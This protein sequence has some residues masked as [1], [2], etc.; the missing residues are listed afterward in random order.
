[1]T[2]GQVQS[3]QLVGKV[4]SYPKPG[5]N[6]K[7]MLVKRRILGGQCEW[8]KDLVVLSHSMEAEAV[9][10]CALIALTSWW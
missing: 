3:R 10:W 7:A 1:M 8:L 9:S 6:V 5:D 4:N 2:L